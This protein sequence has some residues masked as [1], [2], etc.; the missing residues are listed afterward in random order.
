MVDASKLPDELAE[1]EDMKLYGFGL[2]HDHDHHHGH[3]H[4]IGITEWKIVEVNK[5]L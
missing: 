1:E 2:P 3:H 5:N 4:N